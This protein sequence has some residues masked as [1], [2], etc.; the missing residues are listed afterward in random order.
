[1]PTSTVPNIK[2][3]PT[4]GAF[5]VK[6]D[7]YGNLRN[8]QGGGGGGKS[9]PSPGGKKQCKALYDFE[10]QTQDEL[11]FTTGQIIDVISVDGEWTTG[12]YGGYQGIFPTNYVEMMKSA[13]APSR[14]APKPSPG[15][16]TPTAKPTPGRATPS[17]GR[18]TPQ[19]LRSTPSQRGRGRGGY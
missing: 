12:S 16:A 13:P 17:P 2:E 3:P 7:P 1:M 11:S 10:A 4:G 9:A 19:P 5:T 18:A 8:Q 14:S 15:R 6:T